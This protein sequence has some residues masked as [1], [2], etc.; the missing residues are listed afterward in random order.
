MVC[1]FWHSMYTA[2][3][4]NV[5]HKIILMNLD[6]IAKRLEYL[7]FQRI[8]VNYTI[9]IGLS[10]WNERPY[11][12][13]GQKLMI[14]HAFFD[15]FRGWKLQISRLW[16]GLTGQI[17]GFHEN[18]SFQPKTVDFGQKLQ[19]LRVNICSFYENHGFQ[20]KTTDF[21]Q[22]NLWILAKNHGFCSF[23]V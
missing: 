10:F 19:I 4:F 16:A 3:R 17:F 18:C 21:S 2:V 1:L 7:G 20:P 13:K 12:I 11:L 14:L 5:N 15:G 6:V 9:L 23:W 8:H 22:I